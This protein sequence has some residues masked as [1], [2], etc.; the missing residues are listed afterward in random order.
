[1]IRVL[2]RFRRAFG[3]LLAHR[4]TV[5]VGMLLVPVSVALSL[6]IPK[7]VGGALEQALRLAGPEAAAG[8][9]LA[10]LSF[11]CL[12]VALLSLADGVIKY[13]ARS[14]LIVASRRVEEQLKNDLVAHILHLPME[15][16]DR[17]RTGD[18]ISRLT[19][20]VEMVRFVV[21]PAILHGGI[22]LL[23]VPFGLWLM[24]GI[25]PALAGIT[26][27]SFALLLTGMLALMPRLERHSKAT[28]E[29]IAA[30]S[31]RAQEDF[32]GI[33]VLT[34]FARGGAET[35]A[36]HALSEAYL[37][38]NLRLV[39]L[40]GLMDVF[41]QVFRNLVVLAALALGAQAA[42][43]GRLSAGELF[44]FL[45]LLQALVWPLISVGW[46]LSAFHRAVAAADR[47]EEIFALAPEAAHGAIPELQGR[48]EVR[49][50]TFHYP[51]TTAPALRAVSF[52]LPAGHKLGLVGPVGAGKSAL[53]A[54][55]LRLYEPPRGTVF[56]DGI[57]VLDLQPKTLRGLFAIAP[58]DPFL[59]SD[60]IAGNVAF[61]RGAADASPLADAVTDAALDEDLERIQGGLT[62]VIGERGI[63]LSGG[64]KQRVSLA[65]ALASQR[66][67]LVLD[68][69]LSAVDP[70]TEARIL[71]RLQR[72]RG[73]T[74][75]VAAHRLSAVADADL[76]LVLEN[77][78]VTERGTH[79]ELLARGGYYAL[80]WRRQQE[81]HALEGSAEE[82]V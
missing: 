36:L 71:Q 12:Q 44:T 49:D 32:A 5:A 25:S 67:T 73:R 3:L 33:R 29:A 80:T 40:R 78:A 9:A 19:Q 69:T 48:L 2:A 46:I 57:D 23:T 76:I 51:G 47:I 55:L 34:N 68:D 21:G 81:E 24:Y 18:L 7:V 26:V 22:A 8:P 11:A 63:T 14:N 1:M 64:Q 13:F 61:G 58:Q 20:D 54:V 43:A 45:M 56:V 10:A 16:F 42:V 30:I 82:L 66:K 77:G 60:T 75:L 72:Q 27:G 35:R 15:W 17:A 70:T 65:R 52:A 74:L 6:W 31:Q 28:Q 79:D 37:G 41:V 62:A 38:C 39:R 59:F 53:I 4:A 50:L